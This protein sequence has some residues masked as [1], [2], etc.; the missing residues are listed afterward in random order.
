MARPTCEKLFCDPVFIPVP[1]WS[2][3]LG[4]DFSPARGHLLYSPSF[5]VSRQLCTRDC[6]ET[7]PRWTTPVAEFQSGTPTLEP[8]LAPLAD[9]TIPRLR[10][11]SNVLPPGRSRPPDSSIE[12]VRLTLQA[13][14]SGHLFARLLTLPSAGRAIR[15][16]AFTRMPAMR[17]I[18]GDGHLCIVQPRTGTI[19]SPNRPFP[20]EPPRSMN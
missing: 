14:F 13:V 5:P 18:P 2:H 17:R 4:S 1:S 7:V 3:L 19:H 8:P 10:P 11:Q 16:P 6:L 15:S 12:P 20:H 9:K